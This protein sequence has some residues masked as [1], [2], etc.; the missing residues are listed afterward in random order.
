MA[1]PESRPPPPTGVMPASS[2]GSS[3]SSSSAA[4]PCPA[5]TRQS[6]YGWISVAPVSASTA[7]H[8][9]SRAATVGS[10]KR[11]VPPRL[12]TESRFTCAALDGITIHAGMP[13]KRAAQASAAPWLPEECVTTPR[14]AS[15]AESES[16][17]LHAPRALNAATLCRFSHLKKSLEPAAPSSEPLES[18]GVRWMWGAMR[19]CALRIA[20]RST[21]M[22]QVA[23]ASAL[24]EASAPGQVMHVGEEQILPRLGL[25]LDRAGLGH[26]VSVLHHVL[27][28]RRVDN[29]RVV[30]HA[31]DIVDRV[32]VLGY[33]DVRFGCRALV[34]VDDGLRF[35]ERLDERV[36]ELRIGGAELFGSPYEIESHG[37]AHHVV[38]VEHHVH[39]GLGELLMLERRRAE[40]CIDLGLSR[41]QRLHRVRVRHGNGKRVEPVLLPRPER[42]LGRHLQGERLDRDLDG[43]HA[44]AV[45]VAQVLDRFEDRK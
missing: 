36:V 19:A 32:L 33:A 16:T 34:T 39:A 37:A 22:S 10:Q 28:R 35:V 15:S 7:A 41:E 24:I 29:L 3:S 20:A 31:R 40:M 6:L 30:H 4:V 13:R 42:L 11:I 21:S 23:A 14:F 26:E 44:D 43:R 8:A 2:S 18:T 17:A 9:A 1:V 25:D 5:I 27:R 12:C 45:L 38:V